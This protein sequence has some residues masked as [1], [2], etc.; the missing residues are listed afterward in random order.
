[1][2]PLIRAVFI[3]TI[4]KR[5]NVKISHS[6][7]VSVHSVFAGN[8][9]IGKNT[10]FVGEMGKNSYAG[11]N[12]T[13]Y[14]KIGSYC[15]I[16]NNVVFTRGKH[17][18]NE[19]VSTSPVFFSTQKQCGMTYVKQCKWDEVTYADPINKIVTIVGND[20][21]IGEGAIILAGVTIGNGS[22]IAAGAVVTKSVEPYSIV[23]G[24]PAREIKK[25]FDPNTIDVLNK[26][27]WW[28]KPDSW[29]KSHLSLFE[30]P[31]R[32]IMAIGKEKQDG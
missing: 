21:W 18:T 2:Y 29:I 16:A 15:S 4:Y 30:N 32:F 12:C 6:S 19:Y 24:V 17:P 22:I 23:A 3:N 9:R 7:N 27:K 26:S 25:R 5:K 8:N 28:D 11:N 1:M 31:N 20:V 14:G 13:L 10:V